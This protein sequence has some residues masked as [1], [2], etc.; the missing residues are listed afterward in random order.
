VQP[1]RFGIRMSV[2]AVAGAAPDGSVVRAWLPFPRVLPHQHHVALVSSTPKVKSM[3]RDDAPIRSAYFE[4]RATRGVPTRFSLEATFTTEGVRFPLS[5]ADAEPFDGADPEVRR[6]LGEAPHVVFTG[7]IAELAER[8]VGSETNP[9]IKARRF[10]DWIAD[11]ILYSQ[12]QEYS[13]LRNLGDICLTRRYGDSGQQALLFITL[14]RA[15]GIP[16]RW[17]SGWLMFP[18]EESPHA[19][20]EVY[21]PPWGW[22]PID[23]SMA[24]MASRYFAALSAEQRRDIRDF[25]FGGLD[26]YRMAANADH[27]QE[28]NPS[29]RAFRSDPVDFQRGE[30]EV[31]DVNLYFDR[32]SCSF[33]VRPLPEALH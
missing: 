4:Q 1:R 27:A 17:Q 16:A 7:K 9:V 5:P 22:V 6:Y 26:Q 2:E 11:S 19:W 20:C 24:V 32:W 18:G 14:C 30:L 25:Y 23:P 21:L 31:D 10:Y 8:L 13:T 29:R 15:T 28:L 12:A 3:N 33:D